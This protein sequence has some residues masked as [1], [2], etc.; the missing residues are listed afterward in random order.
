MVRHLPGIVAV[1]VV[2]LLGCG[3]KAGPQPA[4]QASPGGTP[5]AAQRQGASEVTTPTGAMVLV[6]GGEFVM[7]DDGA[8]QDERPAHKVRVGAFYMDKY[9]VTQKSYEALMGANPSKYKQPERPVEQVS[10]FNAAKYCNMRSL[11]EGL[12]P[13]Y[14]LQSVRCDFSADGYRLPTEAEWE[15]ACRAGT[16]SAYSFGSNAADLAA[17]AWFKKDSQNT[18]HPVGQKRPNPWGLYDMY[19]NVAE[20]C[21]DVYDEGYYQHQAGESPT[22]PASGEERVLRGGSWA[23]A[24]DACRSSARF[25]DA[26]GFADVC[27]GYDAYGFRCVRRSPD[28]AQ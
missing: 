2:A 6:P 18:T 14:D 12:T 26:P 17:Y 20:W 7:G 19:G 3:Q 11:R 23:V 16:T 9:E 22:G 4:A 13:C 15:Y 28:G 1:L 5:A 27:F 10:W 24:A 25:S 21:Y 8:E